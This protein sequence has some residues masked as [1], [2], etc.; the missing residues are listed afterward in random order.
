[1]RLFQCDRFDINE[2]RLFLQQHISKKGGFHMK[3]NYVLDTYVTR[4][5][6]I[7]LLFRLSSSPKKGTSQKLTLK[8][9]SAIRKYANIQQLSLI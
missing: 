2:L 8:R 3:K 5:Y 1:M 9:L 6:R 4:R 7:W